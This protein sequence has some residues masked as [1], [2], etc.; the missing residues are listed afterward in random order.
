MAKVTNW[1]IKRQL[2]KFIL[3]AGWIGLEVSQVG[4]PVEDVE[5]NEQREHKDEE[6]HVDLAVE[7]LVR[8]ELDEDQLQDKAKEA[9]QDAEDDPNADGRIAPALRH[10]VI[11]YKQ[12]DTT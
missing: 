6:G 2:N 3:L 9:E 11:R 10:K 8:L 1:T 4:G 12:C 7:A 5:E